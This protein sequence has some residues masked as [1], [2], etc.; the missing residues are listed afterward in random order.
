MILFKFL[1]PIQNGQDWLHYLIFDI[2]KVLSAF[3]IFFIIII[4]NLYKFEYSY[5]LLNFWIFI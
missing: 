1:F 3:I 2:T 4:Y 5:L